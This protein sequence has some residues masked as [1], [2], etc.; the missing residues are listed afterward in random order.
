[1]Q[2]DT[3]VHLDERI[4]ALQTAGDQ[5]RILMLPNPELMLIFIRPAVRW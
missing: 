4:K 2:I 3:G 1:V 5:R